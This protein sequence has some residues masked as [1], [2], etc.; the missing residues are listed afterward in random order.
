MTLAEGQQASNES[1][2]KNFP[3]TPLA[4]NNNA[5]I[6]FKRPPLVNKLIRNG[7]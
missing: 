1:D 6:L 4:K 7:L 5:E 2:F 3:I